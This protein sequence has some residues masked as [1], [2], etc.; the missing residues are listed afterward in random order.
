MTLT[1]QETGCAHTGAWTIIYVWTGH[2]SDFQ[3]PVQKS[4]PI[5]RH[6]RDMLGDDFGK[7]VD[8]DVLE[9]WDYWDHQGIL[10]YKPRVRKTARVM[11]RGNWV[12]VYHDFGLT[13]AVDWTD[14]S[15]LIFANE[16]V[17]LTTTT[18]TLIGLVQKHALVM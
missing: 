8:Y 3:L 11:I 18:A 15:P 7:E 10:V 6:I 5:P 14:P 12:L 2:L 13:P 4:K 1:H 16:V 17:T 9:S